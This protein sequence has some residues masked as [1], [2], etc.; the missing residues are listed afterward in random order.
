MKSRTLYRLHSAMQF[1]RIV[2]YRLLPINS[3]ASIFK[4][5]F[6]GYDDILTRSPVSILDLFPY[7]HARTRTKQ[8]S[9]YDERLVSSFNFSD[10]CTY[11]RR[12]EKDRYKG[13]ES[14]RRTEIWGER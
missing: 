3:Y 9:L 14:G 5:C 2:I 10:V 6:C 12:E 4:I 1:S 8:K 13:V 7:I 11:W